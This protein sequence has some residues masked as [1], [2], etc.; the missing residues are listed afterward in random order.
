M[1]VYIADAFADSPFG[2]NPAGVAY[3]DK[4]QSFP[5]EAFMKR[6]AA[7]LKHSETAF[8]LPLSKNHFHIRYFTPTDEV[9]LCGHAT[10][11]SFCVLKSLQLTDG[12][13]CTAVTKAGELDITFEGDTVLMSMAPAKNIR[14]FSDKEAAEFYEAFGLTANDCF[15]GMPPKAVSTGL[16]DIMLSVKDKTVLSQLKPDFKKIAALSKHYDVV[17]FHV[18]TPSDSSGVTAYCRNFA[19]LYGIDEEAATGTSNGALTHYLNSHG[20]ILPKAINTFVQGE[21]MGRPSVIQSCLKDNRI[22][23]G[24]TAVILFGGEFCF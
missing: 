13:P 12:T 19:P 11:A 4:E 21:T 20:R 24:G 8:I 2:G 18:F 14:D 5:E 1:R 6:L 16:P 15:I 9:D 3:L 23:I 10:I 17:G 7:E 22:Y